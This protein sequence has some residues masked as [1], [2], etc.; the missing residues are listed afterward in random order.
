MYSSG[1]GARARA[2]TGGAEAE[3]GAARGGA[4]APLAGDAAVLVGAVG[5]AGA[6]VHTHAHGRTAHVR[7]LVGTHI[8]ICRGMDG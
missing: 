2:R 1:W 5:A 3:A 7:M 8:D 6:A 4:R